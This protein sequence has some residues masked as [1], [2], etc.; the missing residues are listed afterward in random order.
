[1][2]QQQVHVI[3]A[4]T[5]ELLS[6][7]VQDMLLGEVVTLSADDAD[8]GLQVYGPTAD[9]QIVQRLVECERTLSVAVY[10]GGIEEIDTPVDHRADDS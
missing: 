6:N 5:G 1:M 4:Q 8:L 10:V 2:Q 3:G 7:G 9:T